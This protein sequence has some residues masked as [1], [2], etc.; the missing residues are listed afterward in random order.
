MAQISVQKALDGTTTKSVLNITESDRNST[1]TTFSLNIKTNFVYSGGYIG[2]TESLQGIVRI[3]GTGMTAQSKTIT[4]KSSSESWSGTTVHS[5]ND[6]FEVTIP[7]NVTNVTINYTLKHNPSSDSVSGSTSM[8]LT[9]LISTLNSFANNSSLNIEQPL[10]L[11]ISQYD[12]NYTNDLILYFRDAENNMTEITTWQDV[13]NGQ[14]I[15]LTQ[16]QVDW[17]YSLTPDNKFYSLTWRLKTLNN[18]TQMGSMDLPSVGLITDANPIFADFIYEDSNLITTTLT[19]DNQAIIGGFSTVKV[20]IPTKAIA[21]KGATIVSYLLADVAV[22][23]SENEV[24]TEI[25]KYNSDEI[26]VSAIDSRGNTTTLTKKIQD[27]KVYEPIEVEETNATIERNNGSEEGT[28]I[29][30]SGTFW[31]GNFGVV[32]NSL[33]VSYKYREAGSTSEYISGLTNIVPDTSEKNFSVTDKYILGDTNEG[34]NTADSFEI[35]VIIEDE[36]SIHEIEYR[37]DPGVDAIVI[38]GNK[39]IKINGINYVPLEDTY[40]IDAELESDF[41]LYN[42]SSYCRYRKIGK[43]VNIQFVL[44]PTSADNVLNSA[45]ETTAFV[46][47]EE[48]RPQQNLVNLCQGT[49]TNIFDVAV[50]KN[51]NVTIS[52]YRNS[53]SYSSTPPGTTTWLPAN[54]TYFVD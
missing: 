41:K 51:G 36:L 43:I 50:I 38:E 44:S 16:E 24:S 4:L 47:P 21:Q 45:T 53:S 31:N 22:Q 32:D 11:S 42:S 10:T 25:A 5:K 52:R 1:K 3:S 29:N 39:V 28:I 13:T 40:W 34:F 48:F 12:A 20:T 8:S 2:T 33:K 49:S 15:Q 18:G 37:L 9:K 35:V 14:E 30:F 27:F 19:G 6:T 17:I 54:I 26:V 7:S 46:L 23:E